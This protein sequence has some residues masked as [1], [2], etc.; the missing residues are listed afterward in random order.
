MPTI[1]YKPKKR[2]ITFEIWLDTPDKNGKDR[3]ITGESDTL[4]LPDVEGYYIYREDH[5]AGGAT[6][7]KHD[8]IVADPGQVKR[9]RWEEHVEA[10]DD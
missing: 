7:R 2:R 8:L 10:F 9:V 1:Q 6:V 5:V 4:D 3:K